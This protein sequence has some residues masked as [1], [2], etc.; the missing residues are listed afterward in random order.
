MMAAADVWLK[1][2]RKVTVGGRELILMPLPLTRLYKVLDW[3]EEASKDVIKE[4]ITAESKEIP[5]PLILIGRVLNKVD[6]PVLIN[7][8]FSAPKDPDTREPLNKGISKEFFEEYLDIAT[9]H[10]IAKAFFEINE[11]G[12]ILKNL[13]SLPL[14]KELNKA[15][16]LTFGIPSLNSLQQSMDTPQSKQE[17]SLSPKSTDSLTPA[18]SEELESGRVN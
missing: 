17:G 14:V 2:G 12:D 5:N 8:I 11:L 15:A 4:T 9:A 3:L 13:Q 18:N 10:K 6:M 16:S 1:S 7:E